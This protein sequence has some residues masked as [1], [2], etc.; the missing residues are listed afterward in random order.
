LPVKSSYFKAL[1]RF[2]R[3]RWSIQSR[4]RKGC[5]GLVSRLSVGQIRELLAMCKAAKKSAIATHFLITNI[6]L[7]VHGARFNLQLL[8]Y[9]KHQP[10]NQSRST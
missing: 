5:S 9:L 7:H 3:K 6:G 4:P 2:C 8:E 10:G 1:Q